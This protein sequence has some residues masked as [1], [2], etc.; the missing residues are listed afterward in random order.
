VPCELIQ[1][2]CLHIHYEASSK[3]GQFQHLSSFTTLQELSVTSST[4]AAD[5]LPDME[6][7]SQLTTLRI[8]SRALA[9]TSTG[10]QG[11]A[12]DQLT[13]LQELVLCGCVVDPQALGAFTQL[14]ALYLGAV[15]GLQPATMEEILGALGQLTVLTRLSLSF[16]EAWESQ[17][18]IPSADALKALTASTGLCCLQLGMHAPIGH[19]ECVLFTPGKMLPCLRSLDLQYSQSRVKLVRVSEQQ[20]QQLCSCCPALESLGFVLDPEASPAACLPLQQLTALT[21]LQVF[22]LAE[23]PAAAAAVGVAAQLT[24]LGQLTLTQLGKSWDSGRE[25]QPGQ[26]LSLLQLTALTALRQLKLRAKNADLLMKNQVRVG[27]QETNQTQ[28]ARVVIGPAMVAVC[29]ES[30]NSCVSAL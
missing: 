27:V 1:L 25:R 6:H 22:G 12:W 24:G 3:A 7:L 29:S 18:G 11:K 16:Q 5:T 20:L 23:A 10:S 14:R 9:F 17:Q 30:T 2:T 8:A 28:L 4:F 13:A 26:S 19:Q 21:C 15:A